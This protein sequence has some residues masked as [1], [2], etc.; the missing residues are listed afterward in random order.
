MVSCTVEV[1]KKDEI[2]TTNAICLQVHSLLNDSL[3][4]FIC[5]TYRCFPGQ[6]VFLGDMIGIILEVIVCVCDLSGISKSAAVGIVSM[7]STKHKADQIQHVFVAGYR[8]IYLIKKIICIFSFQL[9]THLLFW[10]ALSHKQSSRNLRL[11]L[12]SSHIHFLNSSLYI[13][14]NIVKKWKLIA[15]LWNCRLQLIE[16]RILG[17]SIN[18]FVSFEKVCHL[19]RG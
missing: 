4:D 16:N 2:N 1:I 14:K 18:K 15:K 9:Y 3:I 7:N 11:D 8:T 12:M 6:S 10:F 13:L 17:L 19:G 5:R